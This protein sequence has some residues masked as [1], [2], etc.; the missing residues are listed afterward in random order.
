MRQVDK[1]NIKSIGLQYFGSVQL[2]STLKD[3]RYISFCLETNYQK[4]LHPNRTVINGANGLIPLSIPLLGGRNQKAFFKD[5]QIAEDGNWRRIHWRSIHDSYRKS[6]WFEEF[7]WQLETLY[8]KPVKFLLDWNLR[9]MQW[10]ISALRL[11]L[12]IMAE[13]DGEF[14]SNFIETET[15]DEDE[16][17]TNGYPVYHQ[18]FI[19]KNGF[20][21]NISILDLLF[22]EGPLAEHYLI[23]LAT[24]KNSC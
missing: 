1:K 8:Q 16:I 7:G 13:T 24:Y 20:K 11:N 12:A 6:P 22:C 10:S 21:P 3:E 18:V 9:T 2:Y 17:F 15:L 19:D 5:V 14:Q 23:T 4:G